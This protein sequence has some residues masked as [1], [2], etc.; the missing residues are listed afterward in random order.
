MSNHVQPKA[1]S[2][3][4]VQQGASSRASHPAASSYSAF[5]QPAPMLMQR[6][7]Q[8]SSVL[9]MQASAMAMEPHIN[10]IHLR[11]L[12]WNGVRGLAPIPCAYQP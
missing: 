6:P 3:Q 1:Q 7:E 11:D 4:T 10:L 9:A 5:Q 8:Q 12:H 2:I